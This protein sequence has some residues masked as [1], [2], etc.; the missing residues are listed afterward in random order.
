VA[1]S[2]IQH[3]PL[4][5]DGL[6]GIMAYI[7]QAERIPSEVKRRAIDGNLAFVNVRY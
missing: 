2:Y 7:K 4:F 1:G 5:P 3:N 6:D